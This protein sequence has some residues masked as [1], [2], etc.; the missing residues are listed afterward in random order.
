[1]SAVSCGH[2]HARIRAVLPLQSRF[3]VSS[4][5]LLR[6][7]ATSCSLNNCFPASARSKPSLVHILVVSSYNLVKHRI[8]AVSPLIGSY[9]PAS[10]LIRYLQLRRSPPTA[11]SMSAVDWG[12]SQFILASI[13]SVWIQVSNSCRL[14]THAN[15]E[16]AEKLTFERTNCPASCGMST[17]IT[18]C[19]LHYTASIRAVRP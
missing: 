11:A 16:I 18:A 3:P 1:M 5:T 17:G 7:R 10:R 13:C 15:T 12:D 2:S 8:R 6:K 19:A 4:A 14:P 9:I